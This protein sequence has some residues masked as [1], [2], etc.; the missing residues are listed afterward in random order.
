MKGIARAQVPPKWCSVPRRCARCSS[1]RR[2][3]GRRLLRHRRQGSCATPRRGFC[4][5]AWVIHE[6]KVDSLKRFKD[7]AREVAAGYECGM[8]FENYNDIKEGDVIECFQ[9]EE[10]EQ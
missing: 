1:H 10:I 7:D 8:G 2:G 4:A 9:M 6:G 5:T 3:H